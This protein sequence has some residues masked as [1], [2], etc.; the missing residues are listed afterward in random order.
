MT[1]EEVM[2]RVPFVQELDKDGIAS[3]FVENGK[4]YVEV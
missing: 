4:I 2:E 1:V 3:V